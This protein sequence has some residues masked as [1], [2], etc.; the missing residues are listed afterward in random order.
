[1]VGRRNGR[2]RRFRIFDLGLRRGEYYSTR[3][4]IGG[5]R[6]Y[7][8]ID[9][10]I[11]DLYGPWVRIKEIRLWLRGLGFDLRTVRAA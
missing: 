5:K 7:F 8:R 9:R 3:V 6:H 4:E 11:I 2:R 10:H 1:M